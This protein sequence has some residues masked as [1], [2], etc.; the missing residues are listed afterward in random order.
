LA[1]HSIYPS[2]SPF[3]TPYGTDLYCLPRV[4]ITRQFMKRLSISVENMKCAPKPELAPQSSSIATI[5]RRL[6]TVTPNGEGE[7]SARFLLTTLVFL[8]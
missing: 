4:A 7:S 8:I 1:L 5:E 3:T 2:N 6:T